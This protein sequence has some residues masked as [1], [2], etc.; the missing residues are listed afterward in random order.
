M[1]RVTFTINLELEN[2]GLPSNEA[3]DA[4]MQRAQ[5]IA[6]RVFICGDEGGKINLQVE[7]SDH[8]VAKTCDTVRVLPGHIRATLSKRGHSPGGEVKRKHGG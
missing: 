5:N 4:A 2:S 6:A 3:L 8:P 7:P 1:S